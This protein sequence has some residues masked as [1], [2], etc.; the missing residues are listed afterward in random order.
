VVEG[1]T[2]GFGGLESDFKLLLGFGLADEFAQ[3]AWAELELEVL[4][5]LGARGADEA[6]RG[7]VAGD[8]H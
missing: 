2:A 6:V 4:L 1:F 3:P 5:F 7:V 8:G